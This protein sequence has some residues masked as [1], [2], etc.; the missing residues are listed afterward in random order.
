MI[1][2]SSIVVLE[3]IHRHFDAGMDR[4]RAAA[5]GAGEVGGAIVASTTTTLMVFI[6]MLFLSGFTGI[7]LQDASLTLTY[8]LSASLLVAIVL[9]PWLSSL[10]L[11]PSLL[12]SRF[13]ILSSASGVIERRFEG[14]AKR[15]RKILLRSLQ[16]PATV[17]TVAVL[18]LISSI[19]AIDFLGF[20]F[21][22]STDMNE[23][24]IVMETPGGYSLE[25]TR[26]K[27]I[28]LD[29]V[30]RELVPELDTA[31]HYV[32][33]RDP[34]GFSTSSSHSFARL[35]L[36]PLSERARR[37]HPIIRELQ[38]EL[39]SAVPDVN[40]R[41]MNGGLDSMLAAA[42]GGEGFMIDIASSDTDA[43]LAAVRRITALMEED[44]DIIKADSD[45]EFDDREVVTR[46][47]LELM[48][49][50]GLAP[51][52]AALTGRVLFHGID[53]GS[54][55]SG[56]ESLEI[57]LTSTLA[58]EELREEQ[59]NA[60][61]IRAADGSTV[62]FS[63]FSE[64]RDRPTL[65]TIRHINRMKS[66]TV[67]GYLGGASV[68]NAAARMESLLRNERLPAGVSWAVS[69][70][71][72]QMRSSFRDL[73]FAMAIAVFLVY[74][75]MVIQFE[76]F[77]QPLIVMAAVP[78]VLIG[79]V[80]SLALFGS[81]LNI[82]SF[83]GVIALAGIVVNN[84][85][86]Q[87][88]YINLLRRRDGMPL[89]SAVLAGAAS[90]LRPILMTTLT[91]VIGIIPMALGL[92][93]GAEIYAPLGQA[94]SGGLATSTLVTLFLVPTLY[95]V[96]ESRVLRLRKWLAGDEEHAEE[97]QSG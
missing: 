43:L 52:E 79:V 87:I 96:V 78:F 75:V 88:D 45:L 30:I 89:V 9:I 38:R 13:A 12:K 69:G 24:Q 72:E 62:P 77:M 58:S 28:E 33:N 65:S 26:D 92:G 74:A 49:S 55:R 68:R 35:N 56:E 47:D 51:R 21:I 20:Q 14:L 36:K 84:A 86:V 19:M 83:L 6:P 23:I 1:V 34:W 18:L 63:A 31:I 25:Q 60:I 15:Y 91:T 22:P 54:F 27:A 10:I 80:A 4:K 44:P 71:T 39:P 11:K 67:T 76:R 40:I 90:R 85:I 32:G 61:S 97:V 53:V 5:V 95:F 73:L 82:V 94:I 29:T 17:F 16:Q 42:T 46:L 66:A 57:F 3:N 93:E 37:V 81:T 64:T 59:F 41:V 50:L 48:G 8:A 2:D 70:S 7:I